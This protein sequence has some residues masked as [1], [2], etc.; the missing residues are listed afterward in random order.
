M[1]S[2]SPIYS[3]T[4]V[5]LA[6]TAL[7]FHRKQSFA[8]TN[9]TSKWSGYSTLD[10]FEGSVLCGILSF[11]EPVALQGPKVNSTHHEC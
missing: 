7:W 1:T 9:L 3:C 11:K 8:L 6:G 2:F 4:R 10:I 5:E